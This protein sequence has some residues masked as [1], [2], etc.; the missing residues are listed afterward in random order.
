MSASRRVP[1][2][3]A[4]HLAHSSNWSV[5]L[6]GYPSL[7][8]ADA[9]I[10]RAFIGGIPDGKTETIS[11]RL[12]W[13]DGHATDEH[14]RLG[15]E[16]LAAA[17][18]TGLGILRFLLLASARHAAAGS[19]GFDLAPFVVEQRKAVG[20]EL[21]RRLVADGAALRN[22]STPP[23][24]SRVVL[25][26]IKGTRDLRRAVFDTIANADARLAADF[27]EL[28]AHDAEPMGW[29][30]GV[31][32]WS[33][34][35]ETHVRFYVTRQHLENA[36]ADGGILRHALLRDARL[37]ASATSY[38]GFPN[39]KETVKRRTAR[40]RS[41]LARIEAATRDEGA[42]R[43]VATSAW[44]SPTLLPDPAEAIRRLRD[45]FAGRRRLVAAR[46]EADDGDA[47]DGTG[48]PA[49]N[50]ADVKYATNYITLALANDLRSFDDVTQGVIENHWRA[51]RD[52]IETLLRAG[53]A[54][55]EYRD[56]E[57]FWTRQLPAL[58]HLLD[59]ARAVERAPRN[60]KL[61]FRPVGRRGEAYPPWVAD[62]RGRSGVYVIRAPG[63]SGDLEIV[64]VGS[65]SADRLH[66]TLTRHFQ[67]W[68]RWKGFWRGQYGEGHDPGLTYD[69][70]TA[71]AAV[72][73]TPPQHA[74]EM[75]MRLIR[76]LRP[77]DNLVG[78]SGAEDWYA[79]AA[80]TTATAEVPF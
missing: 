52:M 19:P 39:S 70:D 40:G 78:Q 18:A 36:Q 73:V 80:S 55:D 47:G 6:G 51:V 61:T 66:A 31:V 63:E 28:P 5:R 54:T 29:V 77:R 20:R 11:V 4:V 76:R 79:D 38:E 37:E 71:E 58:V 68:R 56:N 46:G 23:R 72:I 59:E 43:N 12:V 24:V 34:H 25:S 75:E 3:R 26:I 9:A 1:A 32:Y 30:G 13:D 33:D 44:A 49:T 57:G 22:A 62:L 50:H 2:I 74:Y 42:H 27:P 16:H 41:M 21:L 48:Y 64:Y 67:T 53:S 60:G 35:E 69:R 14:L 45:R 15:P 8:Q 65:S 17:H 10:S 7:D